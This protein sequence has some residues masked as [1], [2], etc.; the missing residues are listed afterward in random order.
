MKTRN[1]MKENHGDWSVE[2]MAR[3]ITK[4]W[5]LIIPTI[6]IGCVRCTSATTSIIEDNINNLISKWKFFLFNR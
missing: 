3:Q 6:A 2:D 4:D 1:K 5:R